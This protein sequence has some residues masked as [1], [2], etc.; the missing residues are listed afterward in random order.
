MRIESHQVIA[1]LPAKEARRFMRE[2]AGFIIRPRTVVEVLGLSE[3]A[4][5]QL[6]REMQNEGLLAAKEDYWLATAKGHALAMAT[7]ARPLRRA[8]AERLI[9]EVVQRAREINGDSE[10]AYRVQ[11]LVVFG[12]FLTG[13]ERPNDVDIGCCLVARFDGEK[14]H[15]MEGERRK[16]KGWFMNTSEWAVWPKVEVLRK[17]KSG[18]RDLSIQEI[19]P[20]N[21]QNLAHKI[22]F[23]EDASAEASDVGL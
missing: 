8:T 20:L 5:R 18:S 11:R 15:V 3:S 16:K 7:A 13:A 10:F 21:V 19:G 14:Q 6:L 2:A 1:G 17:L 9:E 4:A 22:V 23:S 12:S